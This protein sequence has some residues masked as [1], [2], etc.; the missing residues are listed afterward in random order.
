MI[1]TFDPAYFLF[2]LNIQYIFTCLGWS[3][4]NT[5]CEVQWTCSRL[6]AFVP[7]YFVQSN[8][9]NVV[10]FAVRMY[11]LYSEYVSEHSVILVEHAVLCV[12]VEH[13]KNT[14]ILCLV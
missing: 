12:V 11:L 14:V 7:L 9:V 4:S 3:R 10:E 5:E 1:L 8:M 2:I 13:S 6:I